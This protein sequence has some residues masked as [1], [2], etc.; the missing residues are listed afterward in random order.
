LVLEADVLVIEQIEKGV[1]VGEIRQTVPLQQRRDGFVV[2]LQFPQLIVPRAQRVEHFLLLLFV[3]GVNGPLQVVADAHVVHHKALILALAGHSVHAGDS[4]EQV[5]GHCHLVQVHHLLDRS[6]E[7]SQQHVV[8]DH[9]THLASDTLVLPIEGQL[10]ALNSGLV[11][12]SVRVCLDM[13]QIVVAAGDH[14][15]C[16]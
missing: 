14:Y 11:L 6:V 8:N 3:I 2:G 12:R 1:V 4:L 15:I 10:E 16:L 13:R 7:A 5:V 9:D